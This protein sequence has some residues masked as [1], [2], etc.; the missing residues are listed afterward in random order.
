MRAHL[1]ALTYECNHVLSMGLR[2]ASKAPLALF[3]PERDFK[4]HLGN[5]EPRPRP[6]SCLFGTCA[7]GG[8]FARPQACVECT[9]LQKHF[10][11]LSSLVAVDD[12]G[13]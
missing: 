4:G 5:R 2:A 13:M 7:A 8:P 11:L 12:G 9:E 1:D 10:F 6:K 3:A